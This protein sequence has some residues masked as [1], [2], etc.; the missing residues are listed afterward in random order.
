MGSRRKSNRKR[1]GVAAVAGCAAVA[2][3]PAL[4]TV[5]NGAT[6]TQQKQTIAIPAYIYPGSGGWSSLTKPS[7]GAGLIVAN[8]DSGP[9]A[10]KD[11]TYAGAIKKAHGSGSKVIGYVDTGYFGT[12]GWD[13]PGHGSSTSAWLKAI[14][15]NIDT[16]YASYGSSGLGGIFFDDAQNKCGPRSGSTQYVDLYKK[17][18][19]YVKSKSSSAQVVINPGTGT[20]QCYADAADTLVTFEG[21]YASYRNFKPRSWEK[22]VAS[23][24]IWHLVYEAGASQMSKAVSLSKKRNAG[25]LYVTDDDN[26]PVDGSPWGNP[27]DSV[28][29]YWS[30][31]VKTVTGH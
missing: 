2:A 31:E 14:K 28:P 19:D 25:Y 20:D 27:W 23:S 11:A 9:G 15:K 13:V 17:I 4:L 24:K 16:W 3:V 21:S 1:L 10:G 22:S 29:S 18:R 12:T 7:P 8:P 30:K 5:A 6:K 26:T